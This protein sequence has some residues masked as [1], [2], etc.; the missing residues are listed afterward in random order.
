[1]DNDDQAH[2]TRGAG[3]STNGVG[4]NSDPRPV[5]TSPGKHRRNGPPETAD[6]NLARILR[7]ATSAAVV[8]ASHSTPQNAY[9]VLVWELEQ[10]GITPD[11]AA[12]SDAA[13]QIS[14][15]LRPVGLRVHQPGRRR[16]SES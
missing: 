4:W 8:K 11:A 10:R 12:T 9:A 15:G 7:E 6:T 3:V 1:M 16:R 5:N 14:S 2:P 13:F